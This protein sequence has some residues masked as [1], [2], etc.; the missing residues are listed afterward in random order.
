MVGEKIIPMKKLLLLV[1]LVLIFFSQMGQAFKDNKYYKGNQIGVTW[2]GYDI[3][4]DQFRHYYEQACSRAKIK[5]FRFH[6]LRACAITN[7]FLKGWSVAEVS[8]VSGHKTWSE[9]K[10]YTRIKPLDLVKKINKEVAI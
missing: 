9:L 10:R 7:L 6:D 4:R 5:D 2:K 3:K 1:G 8:V